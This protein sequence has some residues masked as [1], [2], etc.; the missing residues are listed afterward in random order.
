MAWAVRKPRR[1][2]AGLA[3]ALALGAAAL[4]VQVF[5]FTRLKLDWQ[6]HAYGSVVLINGGFAFGLM[7]SAL[8][9]IGLVLLWGWRGRYFEL[10]PVVA[11][12]TALY[13]FSTVAAWLVT[14][15]ALYLTPYMT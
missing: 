9:M 4:A 12:N 8:I 6:G 11:P 15:A 10:H 1:L 13:W 14:L 7:A 5:D 2:R 3:A